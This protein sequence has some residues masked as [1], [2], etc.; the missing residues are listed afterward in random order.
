MLQFLKYVL[1]TLVGLFLFFV[2]S[3]FIIAGIG[4]M[5]SSGTDVT[6]VKPNSV[7]SIDLN[8][9]ITEMAAKDDPFSDIFGGGVKKIGLNQLK[10][11]I[12]NAKLDPNVKA[13]SLKLEYPMAGFATIEEL[14]NALIDFKKS[15]KPVF[16]YAE[17]MTEKAVYLASVATKSFINPTG[18]I[19]FNGLDA[20]IPFLKGMFDK[21][22]AIRLFPPPIRKLAL[23]PACATEFAT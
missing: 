18:G 15:G 4:T 2:V 8:S 9:S 17:I 5:L 19:E 13:I 12:E 11:T 16:T 22:G 6:E 1:A 3:F 21:L 14:R 7:L 20:E 10:S 23:L